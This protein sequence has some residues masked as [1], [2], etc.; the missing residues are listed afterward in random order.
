MGSINMNEWMI[1][2]NTVFG[3]L[4]TLLLYA[5]RGQSS[6]NTLILYSIYA[7]VVIGLA[8]FHHGLQTQFQN[9][10]LLAFYWL[11]SMS[12]FTFQKR[13]YFSGIAPFGLGFVVISGLIWFSGYMRGETNS[14]EEIG[15]MRQ[16]EYSVI[17]FCAH[18]LFGTF[19]M[20]KRFTPE[21][22]V[23]GVLDILVLIV[24]VVGGYFVYLA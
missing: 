10:S 15:L 14:A 16:T 22:W 17:L 5:K 8:C 11:I 6:G 13:V 4:A 3:L 2:W 18:V 19:E 24:T 21:D 12:L 7:T 1:Q 20:L 23:M 9:A